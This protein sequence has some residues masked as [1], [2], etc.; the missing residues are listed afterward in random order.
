MI[1]EKLLRDTDVKRIY[2]LMRPRKGCNNTESVEERLR[3][4]LLENP[5]KFHGKCKKH[6]DKISAVKGDIACHGLGLTEENRTTLKKSVQ[7]VFHIAACVKFDAP[8]RF[9]IYY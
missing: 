4:I 5:F 9:V 8:L 7:I 1:V 3:K 6:L 2:V